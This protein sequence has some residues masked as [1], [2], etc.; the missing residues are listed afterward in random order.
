MSDEFKLWT[1]PDHCSWPVVYTLI[2]G[3]KRARSVDRTG[4][5]N[6]SCLSRREQNSTDDE[7]GCR[8]PS[9]SR[10]NKR[11]TFDHTGWEPNLASWLDS[12]AGRR[13]YN[14]FGKKWT[15]IL[16]NY[17]YDLHS[18]LSID[19]NFQTHSRANLQSQLRSSRT[20]SSSSAD[21]QALAWIGPNFE[22]SKSLFVN[23]S[24]EN[25]WTSLERLVQFL[26]PPIRS[27]PSNPLVLISPSSPL[28]VPELKVWPPMP[29]T[30]RMKWTILE[31]NM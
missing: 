19:M 7:T 2:A 24:L 27:F 11:R 25:Q 28:E 9:G 30:H 29:T 23:V 17:W 15:F 8:L 13:W 4:L 12:S 20:V 26:E 22:F 5:S 3:H 6:Q 21:T 14:G 31:L 18:L 1:P 16:S 10:T